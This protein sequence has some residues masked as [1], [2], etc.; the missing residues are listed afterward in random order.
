[1]KEKATKML[2]G[3]TAL[4]AVLLGPASSCFAIDRVPTPEP[5]S[6]VLLGAGI[7][8]LVGLKKFFR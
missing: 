5:M 8:G 7:A 4:L 2:F 6:I 3:V 1:M